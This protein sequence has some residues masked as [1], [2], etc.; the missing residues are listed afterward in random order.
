MVFENLMSAIPKELLIVFEIGV[1]IIVAGIL[2]FIF[3]ILRQPRIPAYIITGIILGPLALGIIESSEFIRAMSEIGVAFLLFF[4]GL[5]INFKSLKKVGKVASITGI[6]QMA[7]ISLIAY[8]ILLYMNFENIQLIY[9]I[10]VVAFSSTMVGIKLLSDKDELGTLHGRIVIG[11]LL[12]QD[13]VA[14]IALTALTTNLTLASIGTSLLKAGG[15][16]V[17]SVLLAKLSEPIF[18]Y[19]ARS[20]ELL[21]IVSLGFLFLFSI[22]A[23]IVG[24]SL[25]IGSFFA[26]VTLA[27]SRFKTEIKGR[28][29]PLRDFFGAIL[30]VSLGMQL[31][32]I[33]IEYYGLFG[34]LILLIMFLKP[35]IITIFI[36]VLGY[37]NRT[38]FLT[39]NTLGQSSEFALILL[40]QGLALAHITQGLFSVLV[41]VTIITMSLTGYF[42]KYESGLSRTYFN[43]ARLFGKIAPKREGLGYGLKRDKRIVIVGAHRVGALI[44]K[45]YE[46]MKKDILVVDYNPD[47]INSLIK[48]KIPCLYGDFG[49]PEVI[50]KISSLNPKV[51]ISTTPD[52]ESSINL[53]KKI[54]EKN[55]NAKII[56]T[57]TRIQNALRLYGDGADYVVLPKV[58]SGQKIIEEIEKVENDGKHLRKEHINFLNKIH[59]YLWN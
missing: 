50:G 52:K 8:G 12:I 17:F 37:T 45:K 21:F 22:S 3:R 44:I 15:F 56:V 4:A 47:V 9:L 2:A 33:P 25:I 54:K 5:E 38:A 53:I 48:K 39:G 40:V 30:F 26:G 57:S 32:W 16:V 27:N 34:I 10:L 1:M 46:K 36:R 49:N 58:I 35:I 55:P 29:H 14:I 7:L 43:P 51:I 41:F 31:V 59:Y 20:S 11:I 28:V 6:V 19:A 24:L 23:Y 13:V 42:V 18:K